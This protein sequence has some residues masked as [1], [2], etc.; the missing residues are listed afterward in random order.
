MFNLSYDPVV[1]H[2]VEFLL[3]SRLE[4]MLHL[5]SAPIEGIASRFRNRLCLQSCLCD[6]TDQETASEVLDLGHSRLMCFACRNW[7]V[8]VR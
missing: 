2:I 1:L 6:Q 4:V 5:R 3:H 7:T 8:V